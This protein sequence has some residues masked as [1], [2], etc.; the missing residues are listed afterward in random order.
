MYKEE[1]FQDDRELE[2]TPRAEMIQSQTASPRM[3]KDS[4]TAST[5]TFR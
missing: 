4:Q 5:P 2:R 1:V 3:S